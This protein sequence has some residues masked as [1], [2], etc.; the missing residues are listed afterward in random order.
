MEVKT[1]VSDGANTAVVADNLSEGQE[2]V[3]G[4]ASANSPVITK[5]PFVPQIIRR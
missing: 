5:N 2:I 4:E 3:V 1:G